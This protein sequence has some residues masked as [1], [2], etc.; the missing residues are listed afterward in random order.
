MYHG[1]IVLQQ[2]LAWIV[3]MLDNLGGSEYLAVVVETLQGSVDSLNGLCVMNVMANKVAKLNEIMH[4]ANHY[5]RDMTLNCR[6]VHLHKGLGVVSC[7]LLES[8][9]LGK[10]A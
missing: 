10:M 6:Q 7:P 4:S 5:H 3:E 8:T 1:Y 9:A 2:M